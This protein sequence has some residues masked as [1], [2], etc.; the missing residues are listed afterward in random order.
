V[1]AREKVIERM[2]DA[3]HK[4]G[5]RWLR[6]ENIKGAELH[7]VASAK[8]RLILCVVSDGGCE[9]F[10]QGGAKWADLEFDLK[11]DGQ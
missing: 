4:A 8:G 11:G 7:Y 5:G 10:V 6:S 9:H 3:V 2:S 1:K